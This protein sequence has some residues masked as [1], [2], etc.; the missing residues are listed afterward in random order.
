MTNEKAMLRAQMRAWRKGLPLERQREESSAVCKRLCEWKIY[1]AARC[2]MLYRAMPGEVDLSAL[3]EAAGKEFCL[4]R[5]EGDGIMCARRYASGDRLEKNAWGIWEPTGEVVP[6]QSIDLVLVPGLAFD[7]RGGR[8][9]QG[10]GYYDRFLPRTKAWRIGVAFE[11]QIIHQVPQE[12]WDIPLHGV[13]TCT[14]I[15]GGTENAK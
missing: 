5:M 12:A 14:Q 11:E 2:V 9:G 1:Q 13:C 4:P 8:L 7:A 15:I 6:A 10:G 3:I